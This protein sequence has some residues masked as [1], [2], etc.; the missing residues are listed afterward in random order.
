MNIGLDV[1]GIVHIDDRPCAFDNAEASSRSRS[2][3]RTH[4]RS[5]SGVKPIF[6]AMDFIAACCHGYGLAVRRVRRFSRLFRGLRCHLGVGRLYG[7]R[8]RCDR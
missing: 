7:V 4:S 3:R 5:V 2:A 8:T 1:R 6:G